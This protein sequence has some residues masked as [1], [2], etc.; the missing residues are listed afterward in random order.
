VTVLPQRNPHTH[1]PKRE[2]EMC[3]GKPPKQG[4]LH[5]ALAFNTLLSSQETDTHHQATQ[6][7]ETLRGNPSNLPG[8]YPPS[9]PPTHSTDL[10]RNHPDPPHNTLPDSTKPP[11]R[12]CLK[13]SHGPTTYR[14]PASRPG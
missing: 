1:T 8:T 2:S 4:G 10:T 9:N 12:S 14:C 7:R 6:L 5:K 3:E 13:E 11:R